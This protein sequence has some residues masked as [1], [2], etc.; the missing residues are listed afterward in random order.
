M[1]NSLYNK[2]LKFAKKYHKGQK[3]RDGKDYIIHCI[4]VAENFKAYEQIRV[5][6][7]LHDVLEDTKCTYK[8]LEK[9]FGSSISEAVN[10]LTKRK[11]ERYNDYIK[12]ICKNNIALGIKVFDIEHNLNS[13]PTSRQIN[14]YKDALKIM[15]KYC[16]TEDKEKNKY[17][18]NN[19]S[20]VD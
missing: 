1:D 19:I 20:K 10:I 5:I 15:F 3:R 16:E 12:R 17:E 9:E 7:L 8:E 4:A 18:K 11:G 6:A 2:A 13:T 14:K